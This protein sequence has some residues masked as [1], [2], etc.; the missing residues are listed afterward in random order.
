MYKPRDIGIKSRD[1]G[2]QPRDL[3]DK[4]ACLLDK[5]QEPDLKIL[6]V[7]LDSIQIFIG[8][9]SFSCHCDISPNNSAR[10]PIQQE[11]V[12]QS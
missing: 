10:G 8:F 3:R 5:H 2:T 6:M 9:H 12:L 4:L 11:R 7:Q 1:P